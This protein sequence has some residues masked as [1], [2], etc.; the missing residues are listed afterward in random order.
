MC[1]SAKSKTYN[2]I[3]AYILV[4]TLLL[5]FVSSLNDFFYVKLFTFVFLSLPKFL[6]I[7][8]LILFFYITLDFSMK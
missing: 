5:H 6:I 7:S 4:I 2:L 1:R 8:F 3:I